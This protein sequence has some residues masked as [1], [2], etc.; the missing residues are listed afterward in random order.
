MDWALY[1]YFIIII[2]TI[3]TIIIIIIII[4]CHVSRPVLRK[5][6]LKGEATIEEEVTSE[7]PKSPI[8]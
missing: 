5:V 6:K 1:K 3:I 8:S 4:M 2:I 7:S